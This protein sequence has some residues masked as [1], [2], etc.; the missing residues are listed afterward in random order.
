MLWIYLSVTEPNITE[1]IAVK[2]H[3][4]Q[5]VHIFLFDPYW[6]FVNVSE[7]IEWRR[8]QHLW[9]RSGAPESGLLK[10]RLFGMVVVL[11]V[12]EMARKS[13]SFNIVAKLIEHILD[14]EREMLKS[15]EM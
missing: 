1:N 5:V 4:C 8:E 2:S 11:E 15:C 12:T 14:T 3:C 6:T 9:Q 7:Q 10:S 13:T